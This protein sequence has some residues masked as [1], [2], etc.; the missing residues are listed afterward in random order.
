MRCGCTWVVRR[1]CR[2]L[3]NGGY[4]PWVSMERWNVFHWLTFQDCWSLKETMT[5]NNDFTERVPKLSASLISLFTPSQLCIYRK[6]CFFSFPPHHPEQAEWVFFLIE[7]FVPSILVKFS[8]HNNIYTPLYTLGTSTAVGHAARASW[9]EAEISRVFHVNMLYSERDDTSVLSTK[10]PQ[11]SVFSQV[12]ISII[13][14]SC[15]C[16]FNILSSSLSLLHWRNQTFTAFIN[17]VGVV[18]LLTYDP[19]PGW[20]CLHHTVL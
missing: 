10:S 15:E 4:F 19:D 11:R 8:C 6:K 17:H 7:G 1:N 16:C 18:F 20:L 12:T 5:E 14:T 9:S 13:V 3:D 2:C